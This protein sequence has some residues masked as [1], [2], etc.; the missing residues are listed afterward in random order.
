MHNKY[1]SIAFFLLSKKKVMYM[2]TW[3]QFFHMPMEVKQQ[4]ANSPKTYEGYGSTL[5]IEKGV[6]LDWSD[7]YFLHP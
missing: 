5:G 1:S 6:I 3:R 2:E 4:Y 7:Y